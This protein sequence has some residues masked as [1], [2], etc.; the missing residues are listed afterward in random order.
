ML[1]ET[2]DSVTLDVPAY[3]VDV[4]R[5]CDVVEEVLRIYGYNNMEIPTQ[6]KSSLTIKGD[7]DKSYKLQN[8]VAEQL[9][10]C[11]FNEIL[12][13]SLTKTSYYDGLEAFKADNLVKLMNPLSQ[14]LG[15][16]RQ[17]LLFGGLESISHNIN[18][19]MPD[20]KMFEFGNCCW[21]QW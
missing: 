16:L 7:L 3:R 18:R 6:L 1:K 8:L 19:R 9:V 11:G 4:T 13:N 2:S 20:L 5:P 12:N 10:G 15:V 14:D 17:T 21:S